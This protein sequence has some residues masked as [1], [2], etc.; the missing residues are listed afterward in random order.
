MGFIIY[1][2]KDINELKEIVFDDS[3]NEMSKLKASILK[4]LVRKMNENQLNKLIGKLE[5]EANKSNDK[6]SKIVISR[7]KSA[8]IEKKREAICAVLDDLKKKDKKKYDDAEEKVKNKAR[9]V[10]TESAEDEYRLQRATNNKNTGFGI[11]ISSGIAALIGV[12]VNVILLMFGW[13]WPFGIWMT[14]VG[15]I[16]AIIGLTSAGISAGQEKRIERK[17]AT[18]N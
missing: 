1:E 2:Q 10:L 5:N 13:I 12:A 18:E 9:A 7:L 16:S 3:L 15:T 4:K 14:I 17:L 8:S 11:A 6:K